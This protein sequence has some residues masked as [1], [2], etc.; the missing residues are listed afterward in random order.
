MHARNA[1]NFANI[2]TVDLGH[3][4]TRWQRDTFPESFHPK[5]YVGHDGIRTDILTPDPGGHGQPWP[6][7]PSPDPR[8]TRS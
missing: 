6:S 1:V 4:P 2:H 7:R 8:P 5:L 3:A